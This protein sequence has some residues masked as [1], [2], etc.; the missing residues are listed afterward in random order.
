MNETLLSQLAPS[1][2][3]TSVKF[4][5]GHISEAQVKEFGQIAVQVNPD[6]LSLDVP[7]RSGFETVLG[8]AVGEFFKHDLVLIE[9]DESFVVSN[10]IDFGLDNGEFPLIADASY[11][12]KLCSDGHRDLA[13]RLTIAICLVDGFRFDYFLDWWMESIE[14][15]AAD[16]DEDET[17]EDERTFAKERIADLQAI[18]VAGRM[19]GKFD[20][21]IS[22]SKGSE[23]LIRFRQEIEAWHPEPS[24]SEEAWKSWIVEVICWHT[25]FSK[26]L[27]NMPIQDEDS[28]GVQWQELIGFG[29]ANDTFWEEY[30]GMINSRFEGEGIA[31]PGLI[32]V[33]KEDVLS[34]RAI[35]ENYQDAFAGLCRII[36][37]FNDIKEN[38]NV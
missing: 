17:E 35:T 8:M 27:S 12:V 14:E 18:K 24:T 5:Q 30:D 28:G 25:K 11:V 2:P 9:K 15:M 4:R 33:T 20:R 34:A 32:R 21:I 31:A 7:K 1:L 6:L 26:T 37:G 22:R 10:Q 23:F 38:C 36:H 13:R 19:F 16:L 29:W 3:W